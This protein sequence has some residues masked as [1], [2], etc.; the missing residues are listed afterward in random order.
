MEKTLKRRMIEDMQLR[1]LSPHTQEAYLMRVTLFARHFKKNPDKLGE[2]EIRAYLLHLVNVKHVSYGVFNIT[3]YALKFVFEVTLKRP[4]EMKK[5]PH[6]KKPQRLPVILDRGE[7]Q[8]LL[9]VTTNVKHKAMLMM[10]YGSGLRVSEVARLKVSDIDSARMTVM[11]REGKGRKDRYAILSKVALDT[12]TRYLRQYRPTSWLFPGVIP[13]RPI[14]TSSIGLVIKAARKR[15]G[16]A[17]RA[18]MHSLRHA[19]ATCLLEAGTDLRRVQLLLGHRSLKTTAIY[20]HVSRKDL[21]T[22]VSPLDE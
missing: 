17:K 6:P 2:E 11:V 5:L 8:K 15:A 21:G 14:T 18:T 19:F 9:S 16:I 3:Y 1:G 22:I 4:W 7:V 12:L 13:G 20:L 10:A